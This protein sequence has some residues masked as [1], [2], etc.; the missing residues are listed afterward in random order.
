MTRILRGLVLLLQLG[1]SLAFSVKQIYQFPNAT[2]RDIENIAVRSNGQLLLNMITEPATYYIDPSKSNSTAQLLYTFPNATSTVGIAEYAPDQFAIVVGNYT[3]ATKASVPGSF[4]IWSLDVRSPA[5]PT[6]RK[7]AAIPEAVALNGMTAL[8]TGSRVVMI[9]DSGLGAIWAFN[10][11]SGAYYKAIQDPLMAPLSTFPLGINGV[12]ASAAGDKVYFTNS[13]MGV[14]GSIK[15]NTTGGVSGNA[16]TIAKAV[17]GNIYDDFAVDKLGNAYI[18]AHPSSI[19]QVTSAAGQ[20]LLAGGTN[21][22]Q[23]YQPT[24][25]VF[26]R[27]SAVEECTLYVVGAGVATNVTII[28]GQVIAV[29][30]C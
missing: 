28:S 8:S 14:F 18:T 22:T 9:A 3:V 29:N 21:S 2:F 5:V 17:P 24:S 12:R 6:V 16:T 23:F 15:L 27:S 25:S 19:Y 1:Q 26:G 13:A 4:S 11:T 10:T 7:I 30:I 20:L